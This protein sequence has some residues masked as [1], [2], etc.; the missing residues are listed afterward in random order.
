MTQLTKKTLDGNVETL[1][2]AV[3]QDGP[4]Y[5]Y[6]IVQELN[7]RAPG[8][9]KLGEGTVYPVLH[10]LE[11]RGLITAAW[12][13]GDTGRER[14]YYRLSASGRRAL[15]ANAQQ[16]WSLVEVMETVLGTGRNQDGRPVVSRLSGETT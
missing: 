7:R 11:E 9:L 8:L 6:Q 4:N 12:K 3:L 15:A 10:R 14:K 16:W 13:K 1:L 5:G 2:L